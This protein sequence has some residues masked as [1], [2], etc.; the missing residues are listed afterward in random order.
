MGGELETGALLRK[1][2]LRLKDGDFDILLHLLSKQPLARL[3]ARYGDIDHPS[4][5]VAQ[6]VRLL[7]ML[8]GLPAVAA[9]LADREELAKD[10]F[11]LISA[12]R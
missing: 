3:L 4:Q 9:L 2:F 6:L 7:P 12:S 10:V 8:R 11:A 5:L 1:V